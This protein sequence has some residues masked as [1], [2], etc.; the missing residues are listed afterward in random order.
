[1]IGVIGGTSFMGTDFFAA[2]KKRR[3]K[4]SYGEVYVLY[5]KNI[6]YVPRHGI[7]HKTP[8][9]MINHK[10]NIRALKD[11]GVEE[12]IGVGS[13]GSLKKNIKPGNII[14]PDDYFCLSRIET[15][16]DKEIKHITPTLDKKLR[17]KIIQAAQNIGEKVI[18]G[19]VYVQT[20][21][22]RLETA[23][24]VRFLAD[25]ADVVGMT[26]ASEAT[27]AQEIGLRYAC[28]CTVDNYAHGISGHNLRYE[29]IISAASESG[30]RIGKIISAVVKKL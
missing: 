28:I 13:A 12:V 25:Y 17:K 15:Y 5:D 26:L 4:N 3:I 21:G 16:Y 19:G 7:G 6:I 1:M 29:E 30:S 20:T 27:L 10:A 22:P 23:A 2:P 18:D 9:H 24:E 11:Q 8:P 14:I